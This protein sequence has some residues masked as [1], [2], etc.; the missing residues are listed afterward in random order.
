MNATATPAPLYTLEI[1]LTGQPALRCA[2][3]ELYKLAE[4]HATINE[5]VDTFGYIKRTGT[6]HKF[7]GN[8]GTRTLTGITNPKGFVAAVK[9][10]GARTRKLKGDSVRVLAPVAVLE[11]RAQIEAAWQALVNAGTDRAATVHE[12]INHP[13]YRAHADA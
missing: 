4:A 6:S 13:A 7:Y 1:T 9:A 10:R 2:D 3:V 12:M 11:A 8:E 5:Y